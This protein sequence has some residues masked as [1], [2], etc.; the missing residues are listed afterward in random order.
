MVSLPSNGHTPD[1]GGE[2][3][4]EGEF[5][6][7]HDPDPLVLLGGPLEGTFYKHPSINPP[8]LALIVP[9]IVGGDETYRY[10]L[11]RAQFF[12]TIHSFYVYEHLPEE[13]IFAA[14]HE[15][16]WAALLKTV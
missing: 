11:R 16:L 10:I 13:D 7:P 12:G 1:P 3:E 6:T 2:D 5:I 14:L 9:N 8:V 15:I 4:Q